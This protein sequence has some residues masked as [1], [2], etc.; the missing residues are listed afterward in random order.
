MHLIV[1]TLRIVYC[2]K[3]NNFKMKKMVI[4]VHI[5]ALIAP[6]TKNNE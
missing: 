3:R 1:S 4:L 6:N 2:F 5:A